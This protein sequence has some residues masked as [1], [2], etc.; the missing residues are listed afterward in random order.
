HRSQPE[1]AATRSPCA[2]INL[3][4]RKLS[5]QQAGSRHG[6]VS[7]ELAAVSRMAGSPALA[8]CRSGIPM[9]ARAWTSFLRRVPE[10]L[11]H[12]LML[13][14]TIGVEISIQDLVC[15]SD[16]HLAVRGRLAGTTDSG[17]LFIVPFDQV[18]YMGFQV[19]MNEAA[20]RQLFGE[21]CI[22]P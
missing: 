17:R 3:L 18:N 11:H 12:K 7:G 21:E 5:Y 2:P 13:M 14:T 6:T 19:A 10:E 15:L 4:N 22:L 8:S 9:Q 20:L 1:P 16:D